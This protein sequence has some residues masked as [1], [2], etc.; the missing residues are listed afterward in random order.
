MYKI[1]FQNNYTLTQIN[2][3]RATKTAA[4]RGKAVTANEKGKYAMQQIDTFQPQP[5]VSSFFDRVVRFFGRPRI[6]APQ[7]EQIMADIEWPDS[8]P[9]QSHSV[10][11]NRPVSGGYNEAF[12]VQYWTSYHS[13]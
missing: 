9:N 11:Y 4:I 10:S 6:S 12:I 13:R 2:I 7:S 3:V 5:K 8:D 1:W